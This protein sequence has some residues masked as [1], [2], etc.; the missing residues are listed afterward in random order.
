LVNVI[1]ACRIKKYMVVSTEIHNM[2]TA[3]AR[4]RKIKLTEAT[5]ILIG[6]GMLAQFIADPRD[7]PRIKNR[8]EAMGEPHL[9]RIFDPMCLVLAEKLYPIIMNK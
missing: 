9:E 6:L 1:S 7:N 8:M 4:N 5:R 3:F 2:T